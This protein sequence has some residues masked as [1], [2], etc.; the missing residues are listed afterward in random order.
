MDRRSFLMSAVTGILASA[1]NRK[2]Y[3]AAVIGHTG[4][5]NY[6]HGLDIVWNAFDSIEVVAVADPDDTGRAKALERTGAKKGYQDYHAMLRAE[7][8]GLVSIGPRWLDQRV[9]M[10]EAAAAAGAHVYMEKPFARDLKDADRMVEV[11]RKHNVKLQLAHQMRGS[12]FVRRV[13]ELVEA[14][15]IGLI[16]EVRGRGKED[17]RAGGEDLMVLGSHICDVMRI[18]LGDPRWVVA[19]VTRDGE[20]IARDDVRKPS[21][22][23]GLIAGNQI[24]AMFAFRGGVHGYFS[25]KANEQTHPLRFGTYVYGSKGVIFLP[26]AIYPQGQPY[27]LRSPGWMPDDE[28]AWDEVEPKRDIPGMSD[29][30][31]E[32]RQ[33]ANG[34]MVLDLLEAI[35]HDRKPCCNEEDGRWTIE[36]IHGV[37]TAQRTGN[38]VYFPLQDREHPL[39]AL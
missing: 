4:H 17:R 34:L 27:I 33:I 31:G 21:E 39:H 30:R 9:E 3:R 19:H 13:K 28:H 22:P 32:G 14:G 1:A 2:N 35:E 38:R 6:G 12:P 5:G 10:V 29:I 24:A 15:E 7:K 37:Y 26:N 25:S 16:Q 11:V 8:S 18:F 20:G 23:I 36:M